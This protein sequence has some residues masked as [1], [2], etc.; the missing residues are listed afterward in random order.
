MKNLRLF[1]AFAWLI[2]SSGNAHAAIHALIMTISQYGSGIPP[3]SGVRYDVENARMIAQKMGVRDKDIIQL[4]D[5]Q[6]TLDG[7]RHA[8]DQ[9]D[10]QVN[11]GDEV[12]I[13]YSG[14]GGRQYVR[15][16]DERCAESLITV[17]GQ[18][19]IDAELEARLKALSEK[20]RRIVVFLDS[21]HSGGATTR[22]LSAANSKFTPKYWSKGQEDAC[23]RPVNIMTRGIDLGMHS[24]GSGAK[25]Y[26]YIA[27]ARDDEVSFD[28][29]SKGGVATLAWLQCMSGDAR[30]LDGSGAITAEELRV[31]AQAKMED[32]LKN[33]PDILPSHVKITGNPDAVLK[34]D[35]RA[36]QPQ[37]AAPTATTAVPYNTLKDLYNNRD[38]RRVVTLKAEKTSLHIGKDQVEFTL[39]SNQPGYVYLL[40]VGSDGK[41]FDLLFPNALDKH[42]YIEAGE[43]M[44]LPHSNWELLAQGPKGQDH[45]LAIVSDSTRNFFNLNLKPAGPFS[46]IDAN[47]ATAKDIQLVTLSSSHATS[48]ECTDSGVKTRNLMVQKKCSDAYG[49][50]LLSLDEVE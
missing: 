43:T 3:L 18:G 11:P 6:L 12:F 17:D 42:H 5:G 33:A 50:A 19:F 9:L 2:F 27:A 37:T 39:T 28:E 16:P 45:L 29:A 20:A 30:D 46:I 48:S 24:P 26:V 13:Y 8:F 41:S 31:C 10:R 32:M 44:H 34:L 23:P 1:C 22:S 4:E 7:M 49:A 40:M 38:D 25:N 14:H 36:A 15:D 35:A 21:C 47:A